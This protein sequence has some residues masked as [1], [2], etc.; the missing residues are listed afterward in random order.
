[1][2]HVL[3][4]DRKDKRQLPRIVCSCG[5]AFGHNREKVRQR[6]VEKHVTKFGAKFARPVEPDPDP[7]KAPPSV[8]MQ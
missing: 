6:A 3:W 1:M 7:E 8:M 2:E 4:F 5:W